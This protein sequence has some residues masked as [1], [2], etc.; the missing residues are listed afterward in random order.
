M[1]W[2]ARSLKSRVI[3]LRLRFTSWRAQRRRPL[4]A[5]TSGDPVWWPEFEQAFWSYVQSRGP[6]GGHSIT[7]DAG[8]D[9]H[10]PPRC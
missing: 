9:G 6:G 3:W 1:D 4:P 5:R 2:P 7:H 10:R 8:Q